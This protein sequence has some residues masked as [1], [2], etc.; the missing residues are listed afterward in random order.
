M[1]GPGIRF[2]DVVIPEGDLEWSFDPSGGPGGQHANRSSTRVTLSLD[3][4]AASGLSA[5]ARDRLV[6]RLGSQV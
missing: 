4:D 6:A 2:A 3:L 1:R 5:A